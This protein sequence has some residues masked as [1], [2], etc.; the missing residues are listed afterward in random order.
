MTRSVSGA[1]LSITNLRLRPLNIP[2]TSP[3]S[4]GLAGALRML[5]IVQLGP[6]A[7]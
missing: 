5:R 2:V 4:G 6:I 1:L 3:A 7:V